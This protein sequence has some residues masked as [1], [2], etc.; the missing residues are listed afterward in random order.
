VLARVAETTT[1]VSERIVVSVAGRVDCAP[2]GDGPS[3]V[4]ATSTASDPTNGR[5]NGFENILKFGVCER[6]A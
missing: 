4:I 6:R 2:A 5:W 3:A 1:A